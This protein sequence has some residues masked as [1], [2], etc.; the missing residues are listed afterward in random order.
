MEGTDGGEIETWQGDTKATLVRVRFSPPLT[1]PILHTRRSGFGL[2][3][4]R[5]STYLREQLKAAPFRL[6]RQGIEVAQ[7]D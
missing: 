5:V 7:R 2:R 4:V 1:S 3:S 6:V